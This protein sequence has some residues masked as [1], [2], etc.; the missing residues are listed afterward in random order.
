MQVPLEG[1]DGGQEPGAKEEIASFC[2]INYGV[3]FPLLE[4][5]EVNG[6]NRSALY[7]ALIGDGGRIKWNFEKFLVGHDG[8]VIDRW[9]SLTK[10]KALKKDIQRALEKKAAAA[11]Q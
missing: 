1:A 5:Q 2:K 10:P 6:D 9:T 11:S 8:V 7:A 4:K 3:T